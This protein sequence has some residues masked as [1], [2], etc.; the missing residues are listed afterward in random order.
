MPNQGNRG[1]GRSNAGQ[2]SPRHRTSRASSG[3]PNPERSDIKHDTNK[4]RGN[5]TDRTSSQGRKRA[6]GGGAD[7]E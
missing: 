2:G 3:K 4:G 1:T 6:S 7:N 5:S